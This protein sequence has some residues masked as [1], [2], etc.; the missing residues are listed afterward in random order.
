MIRYS[1]PPILARTGRG[2]NSAL[3]LSG[4]QGPVRNRAMN[5]TT[6]SPLTEPVESVA[7]KQ[8]PNGGENGSDDDGYTQTTYKK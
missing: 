7:Y 4:R 2:F 6:E 3:F 5:G 8:E 1:T